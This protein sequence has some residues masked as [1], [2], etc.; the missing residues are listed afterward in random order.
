M[1]S[2]TV[3]MQLIYGR[4]SLKGLAC[5]TPFNL[6]INPIEFVLLIS[7]SVIGE[8]KDMKINSSIVI[9]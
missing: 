6:Y 9:S 3:I 7:V 1:Q 8:L 4:H 5:T 2:Q